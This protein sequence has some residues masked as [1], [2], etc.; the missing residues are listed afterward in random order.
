MNKRLWLLAM[1]GVTAWTLSGCAAMRAPPSIADTLASTPELSTLSQ[2]VRQA[3]LTDTLNGE[4]PFTLFAPSNE[5]FKAVPAKTM[6]AL[7]KDPAGLKAVLSYH[8]VP[9]RLPAASITNGKLKSLESSTLTTARAGEFVTVEDALVTRADI[10]A[11][12]G[13][14]HIVD[15]VLIPPKH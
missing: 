1:A 4:G 11:R 3:G 6:E 12:N 8:V 10:A 15:Q 5:A 2:L 13:I 7:G 9:S 14:V